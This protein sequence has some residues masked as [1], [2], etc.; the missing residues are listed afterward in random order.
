MYRPRLCSKCP[1]L[2]LTYARRLVS[3]LFLKHGLGLYANH[4]SVVVV[5]P[6]RQAAPTIAF[7]HF[8]PASL[9]LWLENFDPVGR[10]CACT[11]IA[12]YGNV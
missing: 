5:D 3:S 12:E 9:R 10:G 8:Q 4:I 11:C 2:A 1:H 6:F 7:N